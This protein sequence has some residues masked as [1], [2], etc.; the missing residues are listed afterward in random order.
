[1]ELHQSLSLL[2]IALGAFFIPLISNQ[3]H[4][5]PVVG[6]IL[7]GFIIGNSGLKIIA[8]SS[9]FCF[10]SNFG[11][12]ILM[13]ISGMELDFNEIEKRG[14]F[15]GILFGL[16][17]FM[18][19]FC[20]AYLFS[21]KLGFGIYLA[22]VL[23]TTSVGLV[24]PTLK[25]SGLSK[26]SFGQD[27]IIVALIADFLTLLGITV[28]DMYTKFG[29]NFKILA[30]GLAF[31]LSILF[32]LGLKLFVWWNPKIFA[33][34]F[35]SKE[36]SEIGVRACFALMF[37]FVSISAMF[38][39]EPILGSFMAGAV[40]SMIFRGK[41]GIEE[42][43]S[44]IGFGFLIPIFFI[45]VGISFDISDLLNF[46]MIVLLLELIFASFLVKILPSF[47]FFFR[48]F[49]FKQ[50]IS[51]GILISARLSLILAAASIGLELG[52]LS[53]QMNSSIIL[54]AVVTSSLAPVLFK[55]LSKR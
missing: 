30:L 40:F 18:L 11:F 22:L 4:I 29:F 44:G 38:G 34:I 31:L 45:G 14:S 39:L 55:F 52:I 7:F 26:T 35:S 3:L 36:Y 32:L 42:K 6:E 19:T 10:L 41:T 54:L 49:S 51:G 53:P 16:L 37:S 8:C 25:D 12:L 5:P 43:I 28:F 20:F 24:I 13:F 1:M 17:F 23:S 27:I 2:I 21:F 48:K 47:L 50:S 15:K 33:R 9:W 46:N